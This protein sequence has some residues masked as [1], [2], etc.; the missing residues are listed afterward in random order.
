NLF[1]PF[2]VQ[3]VEELTLG[4]NLQLSQLHRLQWKTNQHFPDLSRQSQPVTA[5]DNFTVLLN[6]MEIRT[7]QITWK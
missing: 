2:D 1:V 7:F 6:P 5:T 4:A 3:S